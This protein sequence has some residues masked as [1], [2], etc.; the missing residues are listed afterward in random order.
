[1]IRWLYKRYKNRFYD[2]FIEDFYG[3]IPNEVTEPAI[4]FLAN[5]RAPLER[6]FSIQAYHMQRRS[7][8]DTK[9]ALLYAGVLLHIKSLLA[10][11]SRGK[12]IKDTTNIIPEA[13]ADPLKGVGKFIEEGKKKFKDQ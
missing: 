12:V 3:F 10:I 5:A 7:I 9:N 13:V 8:G 1:M 2:L 6:F 4:D 11:V